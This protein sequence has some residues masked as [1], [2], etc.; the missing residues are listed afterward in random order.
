MKG[1]TERQR[2]VLDFII[3]RID[4]VGYPPTIREIGQHMGIKSTNGVSDH[5]RA[6]VRKGYL[7][8][9]ESKSR[10]LRPVLHKVGRR[11]RRSEPM[12][13]KQ[14]PLLGSIAA[15]QPILAEENIEEQLHVDLELLGNRPEDELFALRVVGNSMIGDGILDGD[16]LFV[17]QQKEA[18]RGEI[19]AAMIDGEATVKRFHPYA[20]EVHLIP[21][22][23]SMEP[24]VVSKKSFRETQLLGVVVGVWRKLQV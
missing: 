15:G 4:E 12:R 2:M 11:R 20:D 17:R 6:L 19:V 21:S 24:I 14:V 10:A 7:L 5:L 8:R 13:T 23:P 18:R 22:N 9:D 16:V 3:D 1:L